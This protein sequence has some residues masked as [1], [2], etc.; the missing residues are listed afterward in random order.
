MPARYPLGL[1][2]INGMSRDEWRIA[3]HK[4]LIRYLKIVRTRGGEF[5]FC[6]F[7]EWAIRE[8]LDEPDHPNLWGGLSNSA[9]MQKLVT[10]TGRYVPSNRP[11]SHGSVQQ[12]WRVAA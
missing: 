2:G 1:I 7:R 12:V 9:R 5:L 4:L 10:G 11:S 3:A 8:G 6:S